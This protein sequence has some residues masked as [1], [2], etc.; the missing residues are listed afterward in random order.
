MTSPNAGRCPTSI[1]SLPVEITITR[2]RGRTSTRSRPIAA[3]SA[4][5]CGP[6]AA[7]APSAGRAG[8]QV[9]A[10]P[11]HAFAGVHRAADRDPG[12]AAV[13]VLERDDRVGAGR[14]RRAGHD[15]HR[16]P[17]AHARARLARR[18][19]RRRRPAARPGRPR[20]AS[21]GVDGAHRVAVHRRV[22]EAGQRRRRRRRSRRAAGPARRAAVSSIGSIEPMPSSTTA[23]CSSTVRRRSSSATRS[24][25]SPLVAV[26]LVTTYSRSQAREVGS[27]VGVSDGELDDGLE[28]VAGGR[29]CRSGGRGTRRRAPAR[30]S[31]GQR[32]HRVGQLD[33]AAAPGSV[34][35]SA[36][37]ISGGRTYRP[38]IASVLGASSG[39]GF[40]TRSATATT[41]PSP[42]LPS[43]G[44]DAAVLADLLARHVDQAR[45]RCRRVRPRRRASGR[46]AVAL[47][48][49]VV[50]QQDR[51]RLA[52]GE[53]LARA[54]P[55]RPRPRGSSCSTW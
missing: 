9:L 32:A 3:S 4:I 16:Q 25:S 11:A 27:D 20:V 8:R 26:R 31:R 10:G 44:H 45:A 15:P 48:D 47:V 37:K 46:A 41:S 30:P 29:R 39:C 40:S 51:E 5:C 38:M 52:V 12:H 43:R 23:R 18:P 28:V 53:G 34:R 14:D 22:V 54:R 24:S 49:Q 42:S 55:R 17:R 6:S 7:P 2:G 36:S 33:L 35:R 1:S 13:G 50:G 21:R 19:R